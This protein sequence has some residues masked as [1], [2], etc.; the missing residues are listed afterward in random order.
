MIA[1]LFQTWSETTSLF[2]AKKLWQSDWKHGWQSL[3]SSSWTFASHEKVLPLVSCQCRGNLSEETSYPLVI[4][5]SWHSYWPWPI[6][7]GFTHWKW[8][9]SIV[10]CMFPRGTLGGQLRVW[11][12]C[13]RRGGA[14]QGGGLVAGPDGFRTD[15]QGMITDGMIRIS[16]H[17]SN[18]VGFSEKF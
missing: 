11:G 16:F 12:A 17:H 4:W 2:V 3:Q 10:F 18:F 8:W 14:S 1:F 9:F 6:Y 7:S 15:Q 13:R 5:H